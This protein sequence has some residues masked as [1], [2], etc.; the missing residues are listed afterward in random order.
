MLQAVAKMFIFKL[1]LLKYI[2]LTVMLTEMYML[3]PF[4]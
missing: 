3:P 1:Q 2:A 4:I